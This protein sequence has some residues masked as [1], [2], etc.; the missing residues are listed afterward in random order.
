MAKR[1]NKSA[2]VQHRF[3][4]IVSS[5]PNL[6]RSK[7]RAL[8]RRIATRWNTELDC[9]RSHVHFRSAI[10]QLVADRDLSL[11]RYDLTE[12]QWDLAMQLVSELKV[13]SSFFLDL[14]VYSCYS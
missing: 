3:E 8:A 1:A 4:E 14:W 7:R 5:I 9:L 13:Y 2:V 12:S 10:K 11:K 6:S